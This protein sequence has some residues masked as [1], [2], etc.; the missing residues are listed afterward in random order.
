MGEGIRPS[1]KPVR[2]G[3]F[4]DPILLLIWVTCGV[5]IATLVITCAMQTP[6]NAPDIR[7]KVIEID[8]HEYIYPERYK[9]SLTHKADCKGEHD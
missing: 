6:E 7:Y 4:V 8:G 1:S 5:T 9:H 3:G 2:R